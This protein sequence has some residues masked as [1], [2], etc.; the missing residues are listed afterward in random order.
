MAFRFGVFFLRNIRELFSFGVWDGIRKRGSLFLGIKKKNVFFPVRGER[1]QRSK[2]TVSQP[3][4]CAGTA[5]VGH[6]Q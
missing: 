5:L 1:Q 2:N 4:L 3:P 6:I